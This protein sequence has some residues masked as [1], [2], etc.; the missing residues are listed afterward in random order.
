MVKVWMKIKELNNFS[1]L[2]KTMFRTGGRQ[3]TEKDI[4]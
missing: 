2:K 3:A 4:K 1:G